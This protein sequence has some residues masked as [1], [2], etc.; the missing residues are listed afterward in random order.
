MQAL[1]RVVTTSRLEAGATQGAPVPP[2]ESPYWL[3]YDAVAAAQL[4]AWLPSEPCRVLDVSG[5]R[6]FATQL[7]GAGHEVVHVMSSPVDPPF[8]PPAGRLLPVVA[9]S[10]SLDW[11]QDSSVD[12]VLAESC[13]LSTCLATEVTVEHL[14][15]ILRPGGRLLLVVESLLLGLARLA[16]QGRWAELAHTPS[17][18]VVLVPGDDGTITRCFW[19]ED[20]RALLTTV[21]LHVDWVR[22]RSVLSPATVE[23]ALGQGGAAALETLVATEL[24]LAAG[25]EDESTG[26]HLIVSARKP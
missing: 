7:A 13:A 21:G 23:R 17:S 11:V 6:R 4:A 14:M 18:D 20:L 26:L 9:D 8:P 2:P 1:D 16:M 10:R 22:P 24:A 19:P 15:R 3:F 12:L 25:R 5:G